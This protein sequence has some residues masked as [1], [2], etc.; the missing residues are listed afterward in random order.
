LFER[1]FKKFLEEQQRTASGLRLEHLQKE[2]IGEKKLFSEVLWPVLK[3]FEG[4]ILEYEMV[5]LSGVRMFIDTFYVPLEIGFESEGFVAHAEKITRDRFNF[6][7]M[8][9]R[10]MAM[11]GYK[12]V[13]FTWDELDKNPEACRRMVYEMLGR[14]SGGQGLV[15]RELTVNEREVLRYARRLNRPFRL[16]DVCYCLQKGPDASRFVLRQLM[17]LRL[18]QPLRQTKHRHHEFIIVEQASNYL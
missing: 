17:D 16:N 6:E 11:Y 5:S 18:I 7:R 13:P 15:N 12:Y 9:V 14:T 10:T 4:F 8:R 2:L 3:S 1:E